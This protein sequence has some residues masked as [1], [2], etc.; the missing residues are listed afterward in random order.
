MNPLVVKHLHPN[1]QQ[2]PQNI[3]IHSQNLTSKQILVGDNVPQHI[4]VVPDIAYLTN[5]YITLASNVTHP[6]KY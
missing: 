4:P 5:I 6:P 2:H 1:I 3:Q